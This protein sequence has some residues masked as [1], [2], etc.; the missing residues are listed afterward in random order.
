ML[1]LAE[2]GHFLLLELLVDAQGD[3]G[4]SIAVIDP[5]DDP[6]DLV[7]PPRQAVLVHVV[8][9]EEERRSVG[10]PGPRLIKADDVELPLGL[11]REGAA[12][13]HDL[14]ADLPTELLRQRVAHDRAFWI[15]LP[16]RE[17]FGCD[18]E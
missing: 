11:V 4:R 3:V 2:G 12:L 6:A 7:L 13:E 14:L 8:P 5:A 17:H 9:M 18:A 1:V 16:R 15:L 10:G